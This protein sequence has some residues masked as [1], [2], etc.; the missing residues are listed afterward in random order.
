MRHGSGKAEAVSVKLTPLHRPVSPDELI[1]MRAVWEATPPITGCKGLCYDSCTNAPV[2]PVE[3]YFLLEKFGGD[4]PI[5]IHP[6]G[7]PADHPAA[8][9][10]PTLGPDYTPCRFLDSNNRCSI[11]EDRPLVCRLFGHEALT[12]RC[13]HGCKTDQPLT[14]MQAAELMCQMVT[15][16]DD[17]SQLPHENFW[18]SM[19]RTIGELEV[20]ECASTL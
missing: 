12:L 7:I 19:A 13:V 8:M 18:E 10:L 15:A 16:F 9:A 14:D 17:F 20:E 4:I 1:A 5:M 3:A 2:H 6:A 11:Y